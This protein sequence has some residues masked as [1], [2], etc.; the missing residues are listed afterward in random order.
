MHCHFFRSA[1][2]G[3]SVIDPSGNLA[4]NTRT[5]GCMKDMQRSE[6]DFPNATGFDW[7]MF[8]IGWEAGAKWADSN[9]CSEEQAGSTCN[10]TD[11]ISIS[12]S[13]GSRALA[14]QAKTGGAEAT[15]QT[16][17]EVF[18]PWEAEPYRLLSCWDME[19]FSAAAFQR[20]TTG[21]TFLLG[22]IEE[23]P[24]DA[25]GGDLAVQYI[26]GSEFG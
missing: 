12:D 21:L 23:L 9:S 2:F 7:E 10:S 11:R 15:T 16:L 4:P 24:S 19:K 6:S 5:L 3:G 26:P 25:E 13:A 20:I 18:T 14:H 22:K 1:P 17:W 8:Q